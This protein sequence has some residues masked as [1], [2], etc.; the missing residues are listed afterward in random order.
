MIYK[1]TLIWLLTIS[2]LSNSIHAEE[3]VI[4]LKTPKT[5]NKLL[6]V[7]VGNRTLKQILDSRIKQRFSFGKFEAITVDIPPFIVETLTENKWI[8]HISLNEE[9]NL[10]DDSYNNPDRG[11]AGHVNRNGTEAVIKPGTE[12]EP[13]NGIEEEEDQ[14]DEGE[15][16][17]EAEDEANDGDESSDGEGDESGKQPD[18]EG[19][20]DGSEEKPGDDGDGDGE[21][22]SENDE[23]KPEDDKPEENNPAPNDGG[24][25]GDVEPIDGGD[26]DG[27]GGDDGDRGDRDENKPDDNGGNPPVSDPDITIAMQSGAP[28]HLARNCR[29]SGLPFDTSGSK[30][31]EFNYY[32]DAEHLGETVNVYILDSGIH[33]SHPEFEGR[34]V[35]G[36]DTTNEGPGD[37]NGHG[38]HVAGLV[39][40]KTYGAAKKATIYEV[41]VMTVDG[42]GSTSNIIA[43]VEFA[44]KHCQQ[45][46]KKCVANMSLGGLSFGHSALDSAVEAAIEEGLVFVVAAGNSKERACWYS[47]AKVKTAITVGAFDDRSDIIASFSNYGKCVDIFA[48]GVAVSSLS[49]SPYNTV[50]VLNGTSMSAPI[51]AGVVAVLLD[52]GVKHE[53][54]KERLIDLSTKGVFHRRRLVSSRTPDRTLFNGVPQEDDVFNAIEYPFE[55][56]DTYIKFIGDDFKK[57]QG[58]SLFRKVLKSSLSKVI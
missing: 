51:T 43:G 18:A 55:D 2:L 42:R 14:D 27:D 47:P 26:G 7:G 35:F 36:I 1:R 6:D 29:R 50:R 28:R 21:D 8:S 16:D 33:K 20:D 39:G 52:Q 44:V 58:P 46:G 37:L 30:D 54:V 11:D 17:G 40:S 13:G 24:D 32:Y 31:Y 57:V 15:G 53:D 23:G 41:K 9:Y 10:L 38:T 5:L 3:Y 25:G 12:T 4:T 19:G 56:E 34:A 22:G 45:S 48:P 49:N